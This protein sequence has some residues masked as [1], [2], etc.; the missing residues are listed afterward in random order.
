M[1]KLTLNFSK[2]ITQYTIGE[3]IAYYRKLLDTT[4]KSLDIYKARLQHLESLIREGASSD[5][6]ME[7]IP[8]S[9]YPKKQ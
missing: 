7:D 5:H 1:K 4:V 2:E 3:K 8:N 9:A 6:F